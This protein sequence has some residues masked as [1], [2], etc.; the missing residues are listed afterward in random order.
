[1]FLHWKGRRKL[2]SVTKMRF[3]K[4]KN[5]NILEGRRQREKDGKAKSNILSVLLSLIFAGKQRQYYHMQKEA[6]S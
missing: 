6:W 1:M 3:H 2:T 4:K 5:K